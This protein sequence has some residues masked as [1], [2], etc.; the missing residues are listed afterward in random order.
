MWFDNGLFLRLH[1]TD[2]LWGLHSLVAAELTSLPPCVHCVCLCLLCLVCSVIPLVFLQVLEPFCPLSEQ[3]NSEPEELDVN[4]PPCSTT[5]FI[6][7]QTELNSS[8]LPSE[9]SSPNHKDQSCTTSLRETEATS[10]S[11]I[12]AA[13]PPFLNADSTVP[14]PPPPLSDSTSASQPCSV[15]VP[16]LSSSP[17]DSYLEALSTGDDSSIP[18]QTQSN[19]TESHPCV[20]V[21]VP[22]SPEILFESNSAPL[23]I[24]SH[25]SLQKEELCSLQVPN[26]SSDTVV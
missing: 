6:P 23:E 17:C 5:L 2:P 10:V 3:E 12:A 22:S 26:Y 25:S 20:D 15:S 21:P 19:P 13:L 8:L 18:P 9:S 24:T 1:V 14:P 4:Q 11:Q 7:S 16:P